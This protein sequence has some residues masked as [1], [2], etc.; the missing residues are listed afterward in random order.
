MIDPSDLVVSELMYDPVAASEGEIAEGF[1]DSEDFEYLE[2]LNT[3][4]SPLDLT[5]IRLAA[6]VTFEFADGAITELA[7]GA[8]VLVVE[9]AAA[10]EF[11]YG[12]GHPVAGQYGGKLDD[13]GE[14]VR[15][16]DVLDVPLIEFTYGNASPWPEEAAGEGASLVL[17]D[18]ASA[19]DHDD[20]ASWIASGVAGGTP[21]Q[22]EVIAFDFATWAAAEGVTNPG[23]DDDGDGLTNYHEFVRGTPPLEYS[24]PR[25]DTAQVEFLGVGGVTDAYPTFTFT[26]S[27]AAAGVA[28]SAE[29]SS[30]LVTW[31]GG[32]GSTEH[33]RTIYH[34]DGTATTTWRSVTPVGQDS[35]Q[36]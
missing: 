29:V 36:F 20:P 2:L 14:L 23:D 22:G 27:L 13:S 6:G 19:P 7:P 24:A 11:R 31:E 17:A 5:G 3:G 8:R 25:T 28:A 35:E 21:G 26:Y 12:S 4:T 1:G 10:F 15:V 30:G 9:N 34:G 18:P 33:V 32:P 16:A